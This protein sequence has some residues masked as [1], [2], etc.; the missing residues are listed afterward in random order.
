MFA[1]YHIER[2]RVFECDKRINDRNT[3]FNIR[4]KMVLHA[5]GRLRPTFRPLLPRRSL[6]CDERN[7]DEGDLGDDLPPPPRAPARVHLRLRRRRRKKGGGRVDASPLTRNI[8]DD[9]NNNNVCSVS[10]PRFK[11]RRLEDYLVISA[12]A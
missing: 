9:D 2:P 4:P 6:A 7:E 3:Y 12:H 11:R 5:R 10:T 8:N 1:G